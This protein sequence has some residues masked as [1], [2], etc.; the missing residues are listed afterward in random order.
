MTDT[1]R[2]RRGWRGLLHRI[3]RSDEVVE[4]EA[5]R[6]HAERLGGTPILELPDR[7]VAQVCGTLRTVTLRP[8]GGVP[9]LVAEL[10]DGSGT[11]AVVWL[12]RRM[13]SG[14][15]PGRR[16]RIRGRVA[17]REGQPI[18][19]NPSYELLPA[20]DASPSQGQLK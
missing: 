13:I 10:Y 16:M 4:A 9:A 15:E 20:G 6:S 11:L 18:V 1:A 7:Q 5:L 19:F 14:V 3:S 12:G 2:N 8:R 17:H